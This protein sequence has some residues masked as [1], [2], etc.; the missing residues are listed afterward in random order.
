MLNCPN[1]YTVVIGGENNID[2]QNQKDSYIIDPTNNYKS[3]NNNASMKYK[4][5][6]H[7]CASTV[8]DGKDYVMVVGGRDSA[9]NKSELYHNG[10]FIQRKLLLIF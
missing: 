3:I 9:E 10:K 8:F 6:S 1:I 5:R 7:S 4:R 2:D